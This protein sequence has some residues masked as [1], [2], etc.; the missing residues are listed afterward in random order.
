MKHTLFAAIAVLI[1]GGAGCQDTPVPSFFSGTQQKIDDWEYDSSAYGDESNQLFHFSPNPTAFTG[2]VIALDATGVAGSAESIGFTAGGAQDVGN[3]RENIENGFLPLPTDI[4]Y[5]GL[6]SEYFF[7]TGQQEECE[8]LFCPS[9]TTAVSQDPFS[10]ETDHYVSV[11]LNSGIQEDEFARKK[12]NLVVV[13]DISGSMGASF[14]EYY[15]D[16]YGNSVPVEGWE[17]LTEE[18]RSK[19][20]MEIANESVA[21]LTKHLSGDDR[22]GV[23]LF[24]DDAYLA[25][26]MNRVGDTDMDAIRDHVL[27]IEDRGGTNMEDGYTMAMDLMKEYADVDQDVYENRIIFLTDAQPN[28]GSVGRGNLVKLTKDAAEESVYTSFIGVGVDFNTELVEAMTKIRGANYYSVHSSREFT[29][30]MDEQF[31]FMVTPLVFD[32]ALTVDADGYDI[33]AVYGSPQADLA[34][35]EIMKVNT[36]FPSDKSGGETRGGV[37]LMKLKETGDNPELRLTASYE[38][39]SGEASSTVADVAFDDAETGEYYDNTGIRKAIALSRYVNVIKAWTQD[40]RSDS[41]VP[42]VNTKDGIVLPEPVPEARLSQWERQSTELTLAGYADVFSDMRAY[43]D[44]E[45]EALDDEDMEKEL[46]VLD[47]LLEL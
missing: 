29:Q 35:G 44:S 18:E 28:T 26:P 8:E 4:S 32:L 12:L 13:L 41:Q 5:E 6:F 37:V 19:T 38:D 22:L 11:G 16:R 46:D 3:F 36:L 27:E 15:Y 2:G 39:R 17:E 47:T 14:D 45:R 42:Q 40:A 25:K 24:D 21:A 31:D 20:K 1:L 10:G 43:I 30:R 33:E 23:V 7:D 9:Y 34:T